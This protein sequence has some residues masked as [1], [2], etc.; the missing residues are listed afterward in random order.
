MAATLST[1]LGSVLTGALPLLGSHGGYLDPCETDASGHAPVE[2]GFGA[3]I[4]RTVRAF[5][6]LQ[7]QD[8]SMNPQESLDAL[9]MVSKAIIIRP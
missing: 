8:P 2:H 1:P 7:Y 4:I 5:V 3:Q 6:A 9:E